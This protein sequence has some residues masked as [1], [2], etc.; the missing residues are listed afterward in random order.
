MPAWPPPSAMPCLPDQ[1]H[2]VLEPSHPL[3]K[4]LL[5]SEAGAPRC[6]FAVGPITL[7]LALPGNYRVWHLLPGLVE[8]EAF[9][10]DEPLTCRES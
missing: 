8:T 7:G 4:F 3:L 2:P 9:L 5:T 1:G 6:P 10:S